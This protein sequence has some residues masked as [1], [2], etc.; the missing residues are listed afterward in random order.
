MF[1]TVALACLL[2]GWTGAVS[3]STVV[4]DRLPGS[5]APVSGVVDGSLGLDGATLTPGSGS[6]LF[7]YRAG[8]FGLPSGGGFCALTTGFVCRGTAT[9]TFARPIT[10]LTFSAFFAGAGDQTAIT[11]FAGSRLLTSLV[12]RQNGLIDFSALQGI[13]RI[14]FADQGFGGSTGIAFG[15]FDYVLQPPPP[16]P[17]PPP[18]AVVPLPATGAMLLAAVAGLAARGAARGAARRRGDG[19]RDGDS[20]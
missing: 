7:I 15:A 3:A 2:A 12:A 6:R 13:T 19:K 14:T 5:G 18:V 9:L 4:F 17:P 11:A 20:A 8:D 16:P 10:G 1:R